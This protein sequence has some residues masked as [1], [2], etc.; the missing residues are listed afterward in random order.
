MGKLIEAKAK[1][2]FKWSKALYSE[3][4]K[5]KFRVENGEITGMILAQDSNGNSFIDMAK[6]LAS[7]VRPCEIKGSYSSLV[8]GD[9]ELYSAAC[10]IGSSKRIYESTTQEYQSGTLNFK[11]Y[12][13]EIEPLFFILFGNSNIT[14]SKLTELHTFYTQDKDIFSQKSLENY[15]SQKW[16]KAFDPKRRK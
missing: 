8:T 7:G 1:P 13:D 11:Q 10:D 3:D 6:Q 14:T 16:Q 5:Y 15:D 9:F 4:G 12:L 2:L